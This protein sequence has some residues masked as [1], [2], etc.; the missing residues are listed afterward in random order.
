MA[1]C[2]L[3]VPFQ[4]HVI[5]LR[6][7]ARIGVVA[8]LVMA[9]L[10]VVLGRVLGPT[11][12]S[13]AAAIVLVMIAGAS[14]AIA[15]L[16]VAALALIIVESWLSARGQLRLRIPWL[17]VS[18]VVGT[19]ALL[20]TAL[21][22]AR[23]ILLH[24]DTVPAPS[25]AGWTV[26][27]GA[28]RPDVFIILADGHGRGDFLAE[29]YG[30]RSEPLR[31]TLRQLGFVESSNSW[32]NH[33]NTRYSLS[34]LLNGR[35]LSELGQNMAEMVDER[36]P[37]AALTRSSGLDLLRRAGYRIVTIPSGYSE[38]RLGAPD[39]VMDVGPWN[40]VERAVLGRT[41]VGPFLGIDE[42]GAVDGQWQRVQ[43][44]LAA[45]RALARE[46]SD[47][48]L[49]VFAHLPVPHSPFVAQA[50]CA[51]RPPDGLTDEP[52]GRGLGPDG[53]RV[54]AAMRDQT[55]CTDRLLGDLLSD[56]VAARPG[57][58]VLLLSD[59]GPDE[60]LDWNHPA[61]PGQGG[62]LMNLFWA[63]T[64]GHD[65]LFAPD[66][67]LVNVVPVLFNAYFGTRLPLHPDDLFFG[68]T[69]VAP[70]FAPYRP[71]G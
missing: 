39:E 36:V 47:S 30:Y 20:L 10:I 16:C 45:V 7:A 29:Q 8:A 71:R 52:A 17:R 53:E 28:Q 9:I 2:I 11:R 46:S 60:L 26:A 51:V 32:A 15:A 4:G 69:D 19:V 55:A 64:P 70:R 22:T 38:L 56:V 42:D 14:A 44:Q 21:L 50:S 24:A 65:A 5:D 12:G 35:P 33:T 3:L 43:R 49:F 62:R 59:H 41:L 66:I 48:P 63:R 34:V 37:V 6:E 57:A 61:E 40:E 31:A 18:E 68:P 58:V 25:T 67:S 27:V 13:A 1:I 23:V 54:I